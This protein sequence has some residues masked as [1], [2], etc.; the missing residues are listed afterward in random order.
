MAVPKH[1]S[2]EKQDALWVSGAWGSWKPSPTVR[3]LVRHPTMRGW[4]GRAFLGDLTG[5]NAGVEAYYGYDISNQQELS[6]FE[7]LSRGVNSITQLSGG[8]AGILKFR[9]GSVAPVRVQLSQVRALRDFGIDK[10]G[11]RAFLEGGE[12]VFSRNT[13]LGTI[14][15]FTRLTDDGLSSVVLSARGRNA[16]GEL[17]PLRHPPVTGGTGSQLLGSHRTLSLDLGRRF[18]RSQVELGGAG[19]LNQDLLKTLNKLR[20]EERSFFSP[21]FGEDIPFFGRDFPIR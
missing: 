16:A 7:R 2:P 19:V 11:R 3:S 1:W 5:V 18:G 15:G 20:F 6:D 4:H 8:A 10:A 13:S 14:D 17:L 21:T 9:G 12:A